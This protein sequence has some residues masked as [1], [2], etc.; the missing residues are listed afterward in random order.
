M[1]HAAAATTSGNSTGR[2]IQY[3]KSPNTFFADTGGDYFQYKESTQSLGA[4]NSNNQKARIKRAVHQNNNENTASVRAVSSIALNVGTLA[5]RQPA[6]AELRLREI[7]QTYE[8]TVLAA[9]P[10]YK[11]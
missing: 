10:Q 2:Y 9:G 3:T 11:S 4:I 6:A 5:S 8:P 7:S 1:K